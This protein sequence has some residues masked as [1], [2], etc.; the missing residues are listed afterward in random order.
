MTV[1]C[2]DTDVLSATLWQRPPTSLI[3]RLAHVS[4]SEQST[5]SITVAE[6]LYGAKRR[7]S[8][9]LA[10]RIEEVILAALPILP[11]DEPAARVYADVKATVES[12]GR[13]LDEPDLRIAATALSR[14]LT[15]VTG[16]LRHFER[17][18]RLRVENWLA[19]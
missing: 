18:P 8:A 17:V 1:Y 12:E 16:N 10:E 3:R 11:F 15:L 7:G 19:S 5:T 9:R 13:R 14:D 6:M 4:P 2:F